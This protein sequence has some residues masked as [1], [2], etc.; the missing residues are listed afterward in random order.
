MA[1][2]NVR[3]AKMAKKTGR[4]TTYREEY[5]EQLINYMRGV[6]SFESFSDVIGVHRDT[7]YEWCKVNPLFSDARKRGRE[8]LQRGLENI[9]KDLMTGKSKGNA[10]ALIFFMKN[11]TNWRDDP[12]QETDSIDGISF[13]YED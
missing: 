3:P 11:T 7:L 1:K 9:S 4:P 12:A 8:G 13:N 6:N 10:A 2:P 5:C